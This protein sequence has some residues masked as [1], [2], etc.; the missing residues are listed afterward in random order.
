M[1]P[2]SPAPVVDSDL[3]SEQTALVVGGTG[4]T[5]PHVVRGL[6]ERGYRVT[7]LHTGRHEVDEIT[8]LVEHIH[9]DPFDVD[10]FTAAIGSA[11]YDLSV[12]MYGRLREIA[13][14]MAGRVSKFVSIGGFPVYSGWGDAD[15]LWPAGM[16]VPTREHDRLVS[17]EPPEF[18]VN[19]KVRQI[20]NTELVVFREHPT[21][22]HLRYP[23]IYGPGQISPRE[24]KIVRRVLD[25]RTRIVLPDGGVTLQ[26]CADARNAAAMVL[27]TVD[28]GARSSGQAYNVSD[29]WTP[30]LLQWVEIIAAALDHSFEIVSI[31]WEYAAVS[32]HFTQRSTPHH[33]VI[34]CD[35]AIYQ[36]GYRD[37]VDP[38]QGL[39]D[40]ARWLARDENHP[41][42]GGAMERSIV[43]RFDYEAE[44]RL[45]DAWQAA[46]AADDIAVAAAAADPG[47]FDR[48]AAEFDDRPGA[49]KGWVSVR[50]SD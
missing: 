45:M 11:T 34:N 37:V 7:I 49:R 5:G 46:I 19:N 23:W 44:D 24:W 48:Y 25:G 16:R 28:A 12:V 13:R 2:A 36:L 31:P 3:V 9:T 32:H 50:R 22:S 41:E 8:D 10:Q 39:T 15:A 4:P 1:R 21:A 33:R 26:G 29:E 14:A 30:T 20:A 27:A 6:L 42:P 38:V 35:K 40:T 17:D 18:R 43:D 47:F